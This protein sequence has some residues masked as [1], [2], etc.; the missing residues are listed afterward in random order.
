MSLSRPRCGH[1]YWRVDDSAARRQQRISLLQERR[2]VQRRCWCSPSDRS[3]AADLDVAIPRVSAHFR[4]AGRTGKP[5][6]SCRST[7]DLT[8]RKGE[9]AVLARMLAVVVLLAAG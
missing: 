5:R 9:D 1:P 4:R 7:A 6:E 2:P 8:T 3:T